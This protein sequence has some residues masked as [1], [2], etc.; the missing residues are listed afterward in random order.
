MRPLPSPFR[1]YSMGQ[2]CDHIDFDIRREGPRRSEPRLHRHDYFQIHVQVEG[3][4]EMHT[5]TDACP[6]SPGLVTFV[7]PDR[8]HYHR[9]LSGSRYYVVS[10]GLNFLR[11]DL[12]AGP[13]ELEDIP[14]ARAP[15]LAPFRAQGRLAYRL[16][17]AEL[18][19]AV[20]LCEAMLDE[21]RARGFF[22]LEMIRSHLLALIGLVCRKY[23]A[24]LVPPAAS[25][26]VRSRPAAMA[27]VMRFLRE[28]YMRRIVLKDVADAVCLSP[29]Y[30]SH[31][32]TRELGRS[33]TELLTTLRID[34]AKPLLLGTRLRVADIA[35][36]CGF[37]D[38]A[39]FSRRFRQLER[40]SPSE[41]R[42]R[43]TTL[44]GVS[45]QPH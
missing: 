1:L 24:S 32:L 5:S 34:A 13:L 18:G 43:T 22:A 11:T 39:Y 40:L 2:M 28:N 33:F 37:D 15:E 20:H 23:A 36:Q 38:E 12:D 35:G 26:A 44:T 3:C 6:L 41:F 10:F 29:D 17:R 21:N 25:S 45:P 8:L 31:L 9:H 4:A 30:L 14:L 19:R 7:M 16:D 27:G 42:E